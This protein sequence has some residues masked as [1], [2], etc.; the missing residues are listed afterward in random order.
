[1][2]KLFF[3]SVLLLLAASSVRGDDGKNLFSRF[4]LICSAIPGAVLA[5]LVLG[6]RRGGS[7]CHFLSHRRRN[8]GRLWSYNIKHLIHLI[9]TR[10]IMVFHYLC[11]LTN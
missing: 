7:T 11:N 1:M 10:A 5:F 6:A 9:V 4:L 3:L 8:P 2:K